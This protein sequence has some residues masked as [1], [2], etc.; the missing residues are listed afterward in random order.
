MRAR[1]YNPEN[2]RF[3]TE[4]THWNPDN[5]IYGDNPQK[6]NEKEDSSGRK[7]HTLVPDETA[8]R[9]STNLYT[10]GLHNPI[11]FQDPGGKFVL[12]TMILGAI[13]GFAINFA[14]SIVG[15]L[16]KG[17]GVDIEKAFFSGLFGALSGGLMG[18]G[19]GFVL[20][21][22]GSGIIG[23]LES[24]VDQWIDVQRGLRESYNG[25]QIIA[26]GILSAFF[27][28]FFYN[29]PKALKH[30]G[31]REIASIV[32]FL[33]GKPF[34]KAFTYFL[35]QTKSEL[36]RFFASLFDFGEILLTII[37][38]FIKSIT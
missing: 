37:E 30:I 32:S 17:N 13:A 20:V 25:F 19:V 34:G 33:D 28:G 4:D 15:S 7:T 6:I 22:V 21:V 10:Y 18:S 9:Q 23:A 24:L 3:S 2:G 16:I 26:H 1:T 27:A 31:S 29:I 8:I 5:M 35:S 38:E 36:M 14:I 11:F 12:A